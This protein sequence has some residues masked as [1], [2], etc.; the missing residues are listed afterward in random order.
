MS[1]CRAGVGPSAF[2]RC[3]VDVVSGLRL[4]RAISRGPAFPTPTWRLTLTGV[5]DVLAQVLGHR[6]PR[7]RTR[8]TRHAGRFTTTGTSATV[9]PRCPFTVGW[10]SGPTGPTDLRRQRKLSTSSLPYS[11]HPLCAQIRLATA[12]GAGIAGSSRY[13]VT[14]GPKCRVTVPPKISDGRSSGSVW[15]KGPTPVVG[16]IAFSI[17]VPWLL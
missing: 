13:D 9:S 17:S 5:R 2:L 7:T 11:R 16:Y 3:R 8:A 1:G 6:R 12:H 15:M 4:M 10:C 14:S